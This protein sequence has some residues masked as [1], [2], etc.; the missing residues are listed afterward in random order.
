MLR[1]NILLLMLCFAIDR[2]T[3]YVA[4]SY[5]LLGESIPIFSIGGIQ[6]SITLATNKGA[7]WGLLV[8][9][10]FLL[11]IL[12][13]LFILA[14]T[15][16]YRY[17][18]GRFAKLSLLFIIVGACSNILDTITWGHVVD[19]IHLSFWQWDYPVFNIADIC[20]SLGAI[21]FLLSTFQP[22]SQNK[23]E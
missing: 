17:T 9:A 13:V 10:P 8:Q 1:K 3:K 4:V 2:I 11:L 7:A 19:M 6:G 21:C 18:Q 5:L 23:K 15:L 20:I 22:I 16:L 14:L 12:R